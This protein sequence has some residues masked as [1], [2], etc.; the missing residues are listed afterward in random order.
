MKSLIYSILLKLIRK[1]RIIQILDTIRNE[2]VINANNSSCI[3]NGGVFYPESKVFNMQNA[4][5]K[6]IIGKQT[7]IRGTLLI[8]KYGGY[9]QIGSNC[10][11][12]DMSRIWSGDSIIIGNNVLIAHNVNILDTNS[13]EL[14][15]IE[16]G[17]RYI[18]LIKEGS[19]ET[20]GSIIT[21]SVEIEDDVWIGFNSI[22]MKGVKIGKGAIIAS[23]SVV[24]KDVSAYTLVAGNPASFV[25]ELI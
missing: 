25:K 11:L 18:S 23:G 12:G 19:W 14:D 21:K 13:H 9:I 16:R 5:H 15:S 10:Y 17:E 20:K 1:L 22:I 7:H 4:A 8:F 2:N 3:N 24:T 6:I